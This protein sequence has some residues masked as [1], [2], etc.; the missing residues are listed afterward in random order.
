MD[1]D[2]FRYAYEGFPKIGVLLFRRPYDK[3]LQ[4]LGVYVRVPYS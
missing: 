2:T 3:D 4:Y 1:R